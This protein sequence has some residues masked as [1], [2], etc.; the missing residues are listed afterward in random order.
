MA[1]DDVC[2]LLHDNPPETCTGEINW[3][4]EA[5]KDLIHPARITHQHPHNPHPRSINALPHPNGQNAIVQGYHLEP[6]VLLGIDV[7]SAHTK[8][9]T[10]GFLYFSLLFSSL[11]ALL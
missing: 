3:D 5:N 6:V 2:I 9:S 7:K 11:S 1:E 4:L 8:L 10:G